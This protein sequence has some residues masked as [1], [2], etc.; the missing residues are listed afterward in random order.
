MTKELK[1]FGSTLHILVHIFCKVSI[2]MIFR[3]NDEEQVLE[4]KK[5]NFMRSE[6]G[7][8]I[9]VVLMKYRASG[10]SVGTQLCTPHPFL[11]WPLV[12]WCGGN[13]VL[14]PGTPLH[15]AASWRGVRRAGGATW[16]RAAVG[17][18]PGAWHDSRR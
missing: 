7:G 9:L 14:G 10:R 15:V 12:T 5:S 2:K 3:H 11:P 18:G 6:F 13:V 4:W 16:H 8:E 1:G 17:G